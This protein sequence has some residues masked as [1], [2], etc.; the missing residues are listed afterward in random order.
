[1]IRDYEVFFAIKN[2]NLAY[3]MTARAEKPLMN[4]PQEDTPLILLNNVTPVQCAAFY[5]STKC[6]FYLKSQAPYISPSETKLSL[7]HFA[8][9]GG[10][11]IIINSILQ[12]ITKLNEIDAFGNSP[13]HYAAKYDRLNAVKILLEKGA[14][15]DVKNNEGY[16]PAFFAATNGYLEIIKLLHEHEDNMDSVNIIGWSPLHYAIYNKHEDVADFLIENKCYETKFEAFISYTQ[17]AASSG[18]DTIARKLITEGTELNQPNHNY[19]TIDHFAAASGCID[20]L[21]YIHEKFGVDHFLEL[22]RL[23]RSIAHNAAINGHLDV[24][25][26]LESIKPEMFTLDD[27][28][29]KTPFLYA[30]EF[31]YP[32]IVSHYIP[33]TDLKHSDRLGNSPLHI[34]VQKNHREI[35]ELLIKAN[36]DINDK[37][38]LGRTPLITACEAKNINMMRFLFDNNADPNILPNNLRPIIST[39]VIGNDETILN[40]LLERGADPCLKDSKGWTS[41]HFAAQI[42]SIRHLSFFLHHEKAKELFSSQNDLGQTPFLTAVFWSRK[43]AVSF[44]LENHVAFHEIVDKKGDNALHI[45]ARLNHPSLVHALLEHDI[46]LDVVNNNGQTAL[47]VAVESWANEVSKILLTLGADPNVADKNGMTAFLIACQIGDVELVREFLEME[48]V[49]TYAI[50]NNGMN[51]ANFAAELRTY[52]LLKVLKES[53]RCDLQNPHNGIIPDDI[54]LKDRNSDDDIFVEGI[55]DEDQGY[56]GMGGDDQGYIEGMI[57]EGEEEEDDEHPQPLF[58]NSGEVYISRTTDNLLDGDSHDDD[59]D[60]DIGESLLT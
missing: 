9:A 45:A 50:A 26:F 58:L 15:P 31:N 20:L 8:A 27:K 6:Y 44:M 48:S 53:E 54:A 36:I 5:S 16:T 3:I 7:I 38:N 39:A 37:D 55:C 35:A 13:L 34:A 22:D 43:E 21:K 24:L 59:H 52:D 11:E 28:F 56:E 14:V 46:P 10:N 17:L 57:G 60:D 23:N 47:M 33:K 30:C 29:G 4:L 32:E 2:D 51:A 25:V 19:W 12:D 1:M 42:G 49:N 41:V 18:L 40:E